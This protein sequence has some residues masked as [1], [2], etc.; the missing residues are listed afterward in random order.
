MSEDHNNFTKVTP[1]RGKKTHIVTPNSKHPSR[2]PKY[3]SELTARTTLFPTV[4]EPIESDWVDIE[5]GASNLIKLETLLPEVKPC[6]HP[7]TEDVITFK[8]ELITALTK[9]PD[10]HTNQGY[11]YIIETELEY[12]ARTVSKRTQTET[13]QRPTIPRGNN[14]NS[15]CK[16]YDIEQT[17]FR[18]HQH[19]TQQTLEAIDLKF[20]GYLDKINGHLP[21][22]LTPK[23]ALKGI[24]IH[25]SDTVVAQQLGN[26]LIR[27]VLDKC[28]TPNQNGPREYFIEGDD[29][30]RISHSIGAQ[31]I[32][33][34]MVMAAAQESF[35]NSGH[36]KDKIRMI[37]EEW[38]LLKD[39]Y[40]DTAEEYQ[41]FKQYY[42]K[43]LRKMY[44]DSRRRH[45]AK[46]TEEEA[47]DKLAAMEAKV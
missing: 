4:E 21:E 31:P 42:T 41:A 18:E 38:N 7:T 1:G 32:P 33:P 5:M 19:Y 3:Q 26:N 10:S 30:I 35:M 45:M 6:K 37:N 9:C 24:E 2:I 40:T 34:T 23:E 12:Q 22:G 17:I 39:K 27:D 44:T 43:T 16:A 47:W 20:P 13:P 28:Y 29:D 8:R 15:A 36:Q 25:V 46:H 14:N 11:A